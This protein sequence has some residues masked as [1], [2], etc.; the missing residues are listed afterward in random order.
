LADTLAE[1]QA[2]LQQLADR[3]EETETENTTNRIEELEKK[4]NEAI[5]SA[6]WLRSHNLE[7]E[8]EV[9]KHEPELDNALAA[10]E[11]ALRKLK[12]ARKV[13]KDLLQERVRL[14][15]LVSSTCITNFYL[16]A[17]SWQVRCVIGKVI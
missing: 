2:R 5:V 11:N 3:L 8:N 15:P 13:I 9:A 16:R 4:L 6:K 12:H 1:S 17:T 7:L 10:K 14:E